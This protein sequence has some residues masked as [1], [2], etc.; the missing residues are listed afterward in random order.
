MFLKIYVTRPHKKNE[1]SSVNAVAV[2]EDQ[3]DFF[4]NEVILISAHSDVLIDINV[5]EY[6]YVY[7]FKQETKSFFIKKIK[8]YKDVKLVDFE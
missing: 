6:N 2:S 7:S 4:F 3:V 8:F 1:Y 5:P